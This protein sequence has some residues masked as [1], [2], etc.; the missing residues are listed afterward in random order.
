MTSTPLPGRSP[1]RTRDV[2]GLAPLGPALRQCALAIGGDEHSPP[3]QWDLSSLRIFKP[4]IAFPLWR[5]RVRP[6]RKVWITALPNR[7]PIPPDAGYS[8]RVT[9]CRDYRGGQLTYDSH[10]GTDF[11]T[12]PGTRLCAAAAGTVRGVRKDMQ[13][14]G[15]K[16]LLDH[17][18][19]LATSYSHLAEARVTV[20]QELAAGEVLGLSGMSGVDGLIGFPWLVPHLHFNALLGGVAVDPFAAEGEESLWVERNAPTPGTG[21]EHV[22]STEWDD[23]RVEASI[24]GCRDPRIREELEGL[25]GDARRFALVFERLLWPFAFPEPQAPLSSGE[26]TA[27]LGLPFHPEDYDGVVFFGG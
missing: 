1:V 6:D 27:R 12:P 14:G 17:G 7:A 25:S 3:S 2:F 5:G 26:R 15:L 20:G 22:P 10:V 23:E 13:R 18:G 24:G 16:V 4:R 9:T 21:D 8:V 11:A 19:G